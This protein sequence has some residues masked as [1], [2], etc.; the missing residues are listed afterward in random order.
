[1]LVSSWDVTPCPEKK[2]PVPATPTPFNPG[3]KATARLPGSSKT[4]EISVGGVVGCSSLSPPLR[5]IDPN[6]SVTRGSGVSR[7]APTLS[8]RCDFYSW[9]NTLD[10]RRIRFT[11]L[12][13]WFSIPFVRDRRD[14]VWGR[15]QGWWNPSQLAGSELVAAACRDWGCSSRDGG[16]VMI[17]GFVCEGIRG[18]AM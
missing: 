5:S 2:R 3:K 6:S 16:G 15:C 17:M 12:R 10:L 7:C 11:S 1:M 8:Q 4:L 9:T 13:K 18:V 14:M